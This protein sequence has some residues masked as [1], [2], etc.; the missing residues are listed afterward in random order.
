MP[1]EVA[2]QGAGYAEL[3]VG[4]KVGVVVGVD[5][6]D[7]GLEAVLEDQ[8]VDVRRAEGVAVLRLQQPPTT[9]SVGI[10]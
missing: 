1:L 9:P 2:D 4:L 6:R 10:G 5:L 7:Q 8:G 3:H